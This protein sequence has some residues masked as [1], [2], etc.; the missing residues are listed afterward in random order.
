MQ[1]QYC[2]APD[3]KARLV[4]DVLSVHSHAKACRKHSLGHNLLTNCK[5]IFL[6]RAHTVFQTEAPEATK[7]TRITELEC[8][9]G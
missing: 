3:F 5:A 4:L 2:F 9:L 7:Q 1:T 6:E 8:M